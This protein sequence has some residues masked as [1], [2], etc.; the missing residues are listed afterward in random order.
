MNL[1]IDFKQIILKFGWLSLGIYSLFSIIALEYS[2]ISLEKIPYF[3]FAISLGC[4]VN[5]FF[6]IT[7]LS[8]KFNFLFSESIYLN[9]QL[10]IFCLTMSFA[11]GATNPFSYFLICFII[12]SAF[13]L[14]FS[15]HCVFI[16]SCALNLFFLQAFTVLF[17]ETPPAA[18]SF[19]IFSYLTQWIVLLVS[20][21]MSVI[22]K[23]LLIQK[24]NQLKELQLKAFKMDN[25][26]NT[27]AMLSGLCHE[28]ASPINAIRIQTD[29][30]QRKLKNHN[31][32]KSIEVI[33]DS[34]NDCE[35]V[36]RDLNYMQLENHSENIRNASLKNLV[37]ESV[38]SWKQQN[39]ES[40][41]QFIIDIQENYQVICSPWNFI[42]SMIH[43]FDNSIEANSNSIKITAT[44]KNRIIQLTIEDNGNGICQEVLNNFGQAFNTNKRTGNGLG[45]FS[46][47]LMMEAIGGDLQI[48][49][50]INGAKV[51]MKLNE[52]I[53]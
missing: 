43:F 9:L 46:S 33:D 30:L 22:F 45:L 13:S 32:I 47:K 26:K 21:I 24:E 51:S 29:R 19:Y 36:I 14:S 25:L 50:T 12:I 4:A 2:Y 20:A 1:K 3:F 35:K 18:E 49:N 40:S 39:M 10:I 27:G 16:L 6:Q 48:Q 15:Q 41:L 23:K 52:G 7:K 42:R 5:I 38:N 28:L 37:H 11:Q 31:E 53:Q 34:L 44:N 8:S 17:F